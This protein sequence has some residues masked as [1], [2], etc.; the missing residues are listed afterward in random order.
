MLANNMALFYGQT[1]RLSSP[2]ESLIPA[3]PMP[4]SVKGV[5]V[6]APLGDNRDDFPRM[7]ASLLEG[8]STAI[9]PEEQ[10]KSLKNFDQQSLS[11]ILDLLPIALFVQDARP[12]NF[13]Q[14]LLWNRQCEMLLGI[15]AQNALGKTVYD[16]FPQEEARLL[17]ERD[18][19]ICAQGEGEDIPCD[20]ITSHTLGPRYVHTNKIPL[21]DDQGNPKYLVCFAEDITDHVQLEAQITSNATMLREITAPIPGW[22]F[23]LALNRKGNIF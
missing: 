5:I 4:T 6:P 1:P 17:M 2:P 7:E 13:G 11:Q 12:E 3:E 16:L 10:E 15:S 18:R 22:C 23:N 8:E 20:V 14:H 9:A 21:V 19:L